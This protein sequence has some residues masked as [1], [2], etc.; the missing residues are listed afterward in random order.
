VPHA[1]H[2]GTSVYFSDPDGAR[3]ELIADAQGEMY[4]TPVL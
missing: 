3:L 1:V 2:S 4:G